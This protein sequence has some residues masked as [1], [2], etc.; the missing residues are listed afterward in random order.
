MQ[1]RIACCVV[2]GCIQPS[3]DGRPD[4]PRDPAARIG[5]LRSRWLKIIGR[6]FIG[7]PL[8]ETKQRRLDVYSPISDDQLQSQLIGE[9]VIE[10]IDRGFTDVR[11]CARSQAGNTAGTGSDAAQSHGRRSRA[12]AMCLGVGRGVCGLPRSRMCAW[13]ATTPGNAARWATTGSSRPCRCSRAM[14]H[15]NRLGRDRTHGDRPLPAQ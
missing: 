15:P 5:A 11:G 3:P 1:D 14:K 6:A 2:R 7:W 9:P 4:E 13:K 10:S 8:A 12:L